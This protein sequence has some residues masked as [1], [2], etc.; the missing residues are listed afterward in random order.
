MSA[1]PSVPIRCVTDLVDVDVVGGGLGEYTQRLASQPPGARQYEHAD[2]DTEDGVDAGEAGQLDH[3]GGDDHTHRSEG[4]SQN[5]EAGALDVEA[6]VGALAQQPKGH[7]GDQQSYDGH[8]EHWRAEDLG[9]VRDALDCLPD[10]PDGDPE[11]QHG[12]GQR[13]QDLQPVQPK[14]ALAV[15]RRGR[16]DLDGGQGHP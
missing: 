6:L 14:G 8:H 4:V 10:D 12:V 9:R 7:E 11:Q 2:T 5:L 15:G 13:R 3:H 16:G 1:T